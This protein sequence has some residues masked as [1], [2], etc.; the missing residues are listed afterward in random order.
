MKENK[1]ENNFHWKCKVS[2]SSRISRKAE[3]QIAHGDIEMQDSNESEYDDH[4]NSSDH[5]EKRNQYEHYKKRQQICSDLKLKAVNL[6]E[7][8]KKLPSLSP[9]DDSTITACEIQLTSLHQEVETIVTS[10]ST[11][12]KM[13]MKL[14]YQCQKFNE[15]IQKLRGITSSRH[16]REDT[17]ELHEMEDFTEEEYTSIDEILPD[18]KLRKKQRNKNK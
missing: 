18:T 12:L 13:S 8:L 6:I 1:I 14:T 2:I 16:K 9:D 15:I 10:G 17:F 4:I 3:T 7:D 11:W 5:K